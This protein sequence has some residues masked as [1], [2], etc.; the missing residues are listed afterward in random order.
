[1]SCTRGAVRVFSRGLG[2]LPGVL[3]GG[4]DGGGGGVGGLVLAVAASS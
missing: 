2:G 3:L 4:V 1:M